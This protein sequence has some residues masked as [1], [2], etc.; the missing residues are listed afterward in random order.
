MECEEFPVACEYCQLIMPN[1]KSVSLH[2]SCISNIHFDDV[3]NMSLYFQIQKHLQN[4]C[5]RYDE[6]KCP[7]N[8][9]KDFKVAINRTHQ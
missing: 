9:P 8:C 7:M 3:Y 5:Q 2:R 6:M 4:E 1:R